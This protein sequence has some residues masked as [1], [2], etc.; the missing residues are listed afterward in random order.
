MKKFI[1]VF[2]FSFIYMPFLSIAQ[3]NGLELSFTVEAINGSSDSIKVT[4]V[5]L[6]SKY[7]EEP[8]E[9]FPS[10]KRKKTSILNYFVT[11]DYDQLTMITWYYPGDYDKILFVNSTV[12]SHFKKMNFRLELKLLINSY[13]DTIPNI[14][15]NSIVFYFNP[16]SGSFANA[17]NLKLITSF[18]LNCAIQHEEN[19]NLKSALIAYDYLLAYVEN[20][21]EAHYLR[22]LLKIKLNDIEGACNDWYKIKSF[23]IN[24]ADDLIKEYCE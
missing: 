22:G 6:A 8:R 12:P 18:F 10:K 2:V 23:V 19:N 17:T 13:F 16:E 4:Q 20:D 1:I 24:K 11:I 14:R 9:I 21:I 5:N 15:S 3:K 7:F